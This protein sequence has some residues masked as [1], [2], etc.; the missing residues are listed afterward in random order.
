MTGLSVAYGVS[1]FIMGSVSDRSNPRWFMTIGLLLTAGVT[2]AFGTIPAIYVPTKTGNLFVRQG[3]LVRPG[4]VPPLVVINQIHPILARFAVP[5][6]EL[7]RVQQYSREH[8]LRAVATCAGTPSGSCSGSP[9]ATPRPTSRATTLPPRQR[10]WRGSPSARGWWRATC[11]TRAS[12]V[13]RP[14]TSRWPPGWI[15]NSPRCSPA[16]S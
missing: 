5:E 12:A 7:A 2:F 15:H 16:R 4:A 3:N 10:S 8:A 11:T 6:K 13:C 9:S 14:T 1:K